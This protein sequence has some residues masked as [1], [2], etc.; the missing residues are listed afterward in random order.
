MLGTGF[1]RNGED[2]VGDPISGNIRVFALV[3]T[4]DPE[5]PYAFKNVVKEFV[6]GRI[7]LCLLCF[8][9]KGRRTGPVTA[10]TEMLGYLI[11]QVGPKTMMTLM[12]ADENVLV[13]KGFCFVPFFCFFV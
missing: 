11:Y 3:P 13:G 2:V 7:F 4:A 10:M 9:K 12:H 5:Q 6:K 1:V 8:A